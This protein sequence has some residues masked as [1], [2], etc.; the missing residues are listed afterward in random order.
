MPTS[1]KRNPAPAEGGHAPRPA[2]RLVL[3]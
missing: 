3:I 2:V 1:L